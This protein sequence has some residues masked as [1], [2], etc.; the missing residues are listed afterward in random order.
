MLQHKEMNI[1]VYMMKILLYF[2]EYK[3][4]VIKPKIDY[5]LHC[6]KTKIMKNFSHQMNFQKLK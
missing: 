3:Q 5:C 6:L 4:H 1:K 2:K